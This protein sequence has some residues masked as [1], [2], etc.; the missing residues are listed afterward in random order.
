M[1]EQLSRSLFTLGET[2]KTQNQGLK[3][4]R[5]PFLVKGQTGSLPAAPPSSA[6]G[7]PKPLQQTGSSL[8]RRE[9]RTDELRGPAAQP[10]GGTW[11]FHSHSRAAPAGGVEPGML[12][13]PG[14]PSPA[15]MPPATY[16]GGGKN[17]LAGHQ[18]SP[19]A[20]L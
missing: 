3:P 15:S 1:T 2:A 6:P 18:Q 7:V 17:S 16:D 19:A 13:P 11:N 12:V 4:S 9:R 8:G 14:R 20:N 5:N 10:S